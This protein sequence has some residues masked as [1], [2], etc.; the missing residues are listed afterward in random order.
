VTFTAAGQGSTATYDYRF[1]LNDG[2]GWKTVQNWGGGATWTLAAT[3]NPGT[4]G[5]IVW[6]RT[7]PSANYD[8]QSYVTYTITP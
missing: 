4:Y 7:D 5:V 1:F 6:V 3:T 2:T 8:T